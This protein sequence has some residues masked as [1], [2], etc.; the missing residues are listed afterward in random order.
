[1]NMVI[2]A[3]RKLLDRFA[4]VLDGADAKAIEDARQDLRLFYWRYD[5]MLAKREKLS[6]EVLGNLDSP[7]TA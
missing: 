1:M 6:A 3:E 2:A 4:S 7:R 5:S